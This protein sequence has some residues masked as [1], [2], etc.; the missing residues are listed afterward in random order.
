MPLLDTQGND[1]A[2]AYG[3]GAPAVVTNYIENVFSTY[4]YTGN[5]SPQTIT[6]GIDLSTKGGLVWVKSRSAVKNNCLVDTV[7]GV[8]YALASN[9]TGVQDFSS[10][11]YVNA[12][13]TNGFGVGDVGD[14]GGSGVTFATWTFRK[15]PKFFDVVTYTGNGTSRAISHNLGS[16]PGCMIVKDLTTGSTNWR[17]YHKDFPT[18]YANL[19]TTGIFSTAGAENCFGNNSTVVAPTST[20]FTVGNASLV[21]GSG[22]QYVAYLFASNAGGFGLTGIDN[23]ITCGS[24]TTDGDGYSPN[25]TLGYEPQWIMFKR[26]DSATFGSWQIV[27]TMRGWVNNGYTGDDYTLLANS[28]AAEGSAADRGYPTATGF[29]VGYTGAASSLYIYIAIR[30]GPMAVPTDATSVFLP[31]AVSTDATAITTNFPVDMLF[32][33]Q[34]VGNASNTVT[35]SRLIGSSGLITSSTAAE[36]AGLIISNCFQSNVSYTPDALGSNVIC[37][38]F[39]RA[40]GFFDEVCY[41]GNGSAQTLSHNLNATPEL[42]IVK[43]RGNT[44]IWGVY[45][46]TTGNTNYLNLS[47][48]D[49]VTSTSITWNNTSPTST[50]FTVG[51]YYSASTQTFVGYLFATCAGVS[52]VFSFTGNGTTQTINC[53]FTSGA[54]F[55]LLK[56]TSTTGGWFVYDTARGMTTLTDPYLQLNSTAAESA[57]LGSVTTVTTGFAVNESILSGVNTNGVSYIGLAIA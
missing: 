43:G 41:T 2:D 44:Q 51:T 27:D 34:R 29:N 24:F 15:Q 42:M 54:R 3:G 9:T 57:T 21:N 45:T 52:K 32:D 23:V 47:T 22:D 31:S 13:N 50:Q 20:N 5:G 53:G 14:V 49:A 1:S 4:L 56:A 6:N 10:G 8:S 17:V 18:G 16:V 7:R 48:S 36:A 25:V 40:P 11:N 28:S 12:F 26:A 38:A 33:N 30:R 46:S 35:G 19:N 37:Y 39:R 55:V